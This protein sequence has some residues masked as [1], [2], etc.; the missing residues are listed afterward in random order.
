LTFVFLNIKILN[1]KLSVA[2]GAN[3]MKYENFDG[4]PALPIDLDFNPVRETV[5]RNGV[6]VPD[7][8]WIVNPHTDQLINDKPSGKN[9]HP[10]NYTRMWDAFCEGVS[11]S[12]ID[13]NNLQVKFNIAH[14]GSAFSA[15]IVFKNYDFKR[16]I[17]EATQMKMRIVDSHDMTFRR[18]I[19]CTIMRLACTNGMSN[20]GENLT[21][22]QKHTMLSDPEKLGA[23]VAE[24]PSRLENEAELYERMIKT[25]VTK[26]QAIAFARSEVATYRVASGIKVNEKSVEE[27]ARIWND[28]AGLG[29]TGY[30]LYNVLTHIGTHVT[31]RKGTDMARKQIR[32]EDKVADIVQGNTF[33]SLVGLAA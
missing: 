14:N 22:R 6:R 11:A 26:D 29:N 8:Y 2:I 27:F 18:D 5:Y 13:T 4:L 24:Y 7:Q 31:G 10:V 25:P 16:I 33:Q 17:G 9:H 28:Y 30:R 15:D 20:V 32:I 21:I 3:K 23:V 12:G 19:R 1:T